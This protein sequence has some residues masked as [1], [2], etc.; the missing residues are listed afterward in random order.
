MTAA[1][2]EAARARGVPDEAVNAVWGAMCE[3][4]LDNERR[5]EVVDTVG[6]SFGRVRALR[7]L[8]DGPL[9][10]GELASALTIDAPNATTVVDDLE[11]LGLVRRRPHPTDRRARLVELTRKGGDI[12][13]WAD[14]VLGRPPAELAALD[15]ADLETLARILGPL[16][17]R[18]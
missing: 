15:P 14:A 17:Q 13:R 5:R 6:L 7:R 12:A 3:L 11:E 4:V 18:S 16:R 9:S 2:A 8:L 10:M 1:R